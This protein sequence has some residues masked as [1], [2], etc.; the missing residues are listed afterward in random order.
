MCSVQSNQ[1]KS[2]QPAASRLKHRSADPSSSHSCTS[3]LKH[4]S[5]AQQPSK[6]AD[7]KPG[8]VAVAHIRQNRRAA[9]ALARQAIQR[10]QAD[11]D[12]DSS[13][14][15]VQ[16]SNRVRSNAAVAASQHRSCTAGSRTAC[17]PG[18]HDLQVGIPVHAAGS[19][20]YKGDPPRIDALPTMS[21]PVA[22]QV[23]V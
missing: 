4:G 2:C 7:S 12:T 19:Y 11:S 5:R 6:G 13:G 23:Q 3:S 17:L 15:M 20:S 10:L 16:A 18:A 9:A 22:Q 14:C 21:L 1:S 8:Y